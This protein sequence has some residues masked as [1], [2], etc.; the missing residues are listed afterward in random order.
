M[1]VLQI[2]TKEWLLYGRS[3]SD[4]FYAITNEIKPELIT[5]DKFRD[6]IARFRLLQDKILTKI[7][8]GRDRYSAI[9]AFN[10]AFYKLRTDTPSMLSAVAY[11]PRLGRNNVSN[12]A[13]SLAKIVIQYLVSTNWVQLY[14]L[15]YEATMKLTYAEWI[16][17]QTALNTLPP[18]EPSE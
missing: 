4:F 7:D 16:R 14:G 8:N 18:P 12:E 5:E 9:I 3:D 6:Y 15:S 17:M 13:N 10:E 1:P 2:R 11:V